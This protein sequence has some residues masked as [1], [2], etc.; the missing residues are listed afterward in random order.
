[1]KEMDGLLKELKVNR[2]NLH[3]MIKDVVG[4]RTKMDKLIPTTKEGKLDFK[5]RFVLAER[6]KTITEVIKSELAIRNQIDSSIKL[7][8]D[9]RRRSVEEE[10]DDSPIK[11]KAYAK[12]IEL[13]EREKEDNATKAEKDRLKIVKEG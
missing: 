2:E 5:N 6:M 11:I 3:D 7:E 4:F 1:M 13:L 8:T 10:L 9:M 12:A